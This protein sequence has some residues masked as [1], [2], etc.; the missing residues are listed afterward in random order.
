MKQQFLEETST[1]DG[2]QLRS[3]FAYL[4]HGILGDS[5][6]SWVGA[7]NI[8][9]ER[10]VDGEDRRAKAQIQGDLMLHFIV[11]KFEISL[12]SA[13]ALQRLMASLVQQFL[14]ENSPQKNLAHSL[15]RQGDDLYV[16]EKKLNISIA[17]QTPYV[18]FDSFCCESPP[19]KERQFPRFLLKI[20]RWRQNPL[21]K[22]S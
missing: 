12:F 5:I 9:L 15:K 20:F 22:V 2:S 10:I 17:T 3:L 4:D 1:Y 16:D 13:V 18:E 6:V 11:E 8:P 7:C 21:L 14:V 19:L